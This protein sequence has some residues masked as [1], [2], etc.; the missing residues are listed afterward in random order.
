MTRILGLAIGEDFDPAFKAQ[1]TRT[2]G[3][4][5]FS[6]LIGWVND[7]SGIGQVGDEVE[8]AAH[9]VLDQFPG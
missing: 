1:I 4:V 3:H 5:W 2:L 7:W 6:A 9:L 8:I